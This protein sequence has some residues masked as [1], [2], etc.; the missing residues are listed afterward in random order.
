MNATELKQRIEADYLFSVQAADAARKRRIDA[1][2]D[3]I[4][5]SGGNGDIAQLRELTVSTPKTANVGTTWVVETSQGETNAVK[6]LKRRYR[7]GNRRRLSGAARC[8]EAMSLFNTTFA[9]TTKNVAAVA[10]CDYP[11]ARTQVIQG[12]KDGWIKEHST[13]QYAGKQGRTAGT[14]K[15]IGNPPK[16]P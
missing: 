13:P 1:I 9:F 6:I 10:K 2:E 3:I 12:I 8:V 4:R 5:Y 14:Y 11:T 7:K 16:T 15:R